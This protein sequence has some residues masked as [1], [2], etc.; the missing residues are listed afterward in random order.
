MPDI[1]NVSLRA[2]YSK[3]F[4]CACIC[5]K[6]ALPIDNLHFVV[7]TFGKS[8]MS[9]NHFIR[10]NS[11]KSRGQMLSIISTIIEIINYLYSFAVQECKGLCGENG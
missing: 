9:L 5:Q 10:H 4:F 8:V 7:C 6:V 11:F 1:L 2:E 3:G